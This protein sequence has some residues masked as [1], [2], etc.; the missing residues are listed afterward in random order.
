LIAR[1]VREAGVYC[2]IAPAQRAAEAFA[3]LSPKAV[4]L[5]GGPASVHDE[6]RRAR[7]MRFLAPGCRCSASVYGQQVMAAQLGGKVARRAYSA[8]VGP[9]RSRGFAAKRAL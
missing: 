6:V 4:I 9:R 1:R 2:E 3:A 5:S 7:R 8:N